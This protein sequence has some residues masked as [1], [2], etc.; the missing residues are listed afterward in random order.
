MKKIKKAFI[1]IIILMIS[2]L[3]LFELKNY[4][5]NE[6]NNA[7]VNTTN[8]NN[9]STNTTNTTNTGSTST[10]NTNTTNSTS[11]P[12]T[13]SSSNNIETNTQKNSNTTKSSNANL[14]TLG[15][16]PAQ[17]DFKGFNNNTLTYEAKVP[18][19]I[20]S[21]EIFAVAQDKK[22]T[23]EGTGKRELEIGKN[24]LEVIVT[25]EDGT[26]KTFTI[27]VTRGEVTRNSNK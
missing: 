10:Q 26:K 19:S 11:K 18:E 6:T 25:A 16:K 2:I 1:S 14:T 15:I 7:E 21:V 22:A 12:S 17:Y 20:E 5:V 13:N 4:A 9:S 3:F 8:T 27:N 23:I 24:A